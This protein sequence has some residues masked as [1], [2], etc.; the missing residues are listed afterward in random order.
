[1]VS[2]VKDTEKE[3]IKNKQWEW[4]VLEAPRKSKGLEK[5]QDKETWGR[6]RLVK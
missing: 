1:M 6:D 4:S 2:A 3:K 5:S